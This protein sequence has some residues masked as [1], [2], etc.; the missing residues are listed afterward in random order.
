MPTQPL[1]HSL[2]GVGEKIGEESSWVKI[3]RFLTNH[4]HRQNRL[5]L[6]IINFN[7]LSI[8][9]NSGSEKQK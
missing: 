3:E 4:C 9:I 8:K 6:R 5:N 1:T 7:L 2:S